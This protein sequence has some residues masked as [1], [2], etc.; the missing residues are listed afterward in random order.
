[1]FL[2]AVTRHPALYLT[3]CPAGVEIFHPRQFFCKP[4]A[5]P[6]QADGDGIGADS[7]DDADFRLPQAIPNQQAKQLLVVGPEASKGL[8]GRCFGGVERSGILWLGPEP[9][10]ETQPTG[11]PALLIGDHAA[12]DREEP[13]QG[14][15]RLRQTVD[16]PPCHREGLG[17]D[18]LRVCLGPYPP[19][20]VG[21]DRPMMPLEGCFK[22]REVQAAHGHRTKRDSRKFRPFTLSGYATDVGQSPPSR[23]PARARRRKFRGRSLA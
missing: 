22:T 14:R 12:S 3:R 5:S 6:V 17:D 11:T 7:E 1:M 4:A 18:V 10:V 19:K 21:E 15:L 23:R 13:R 16:P 20:G 9:E 8:Q 2:M